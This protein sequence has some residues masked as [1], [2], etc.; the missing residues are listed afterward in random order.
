VFGLVQPDWMVTRQPPLV[1]QQRPFKAGQ[2]SVVVQV[3]PAPRKELVP[4]Q[5][6]PPA[7]EATKQ[8]PTL[9]QH[10]PV[11]PVQML[12]VV[13]TVPTPLNEPL[14]ARTTVTEQMPAV[15]QQAPRRALHGASVPTVVVAQVVPV[16][17]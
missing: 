7:L 11:R 12:E 14:Q 17:L 8:P 4:V 13:Q 6:F 3:V 16:P 15:E 10:A 1:V 5:P 9:E 2:G